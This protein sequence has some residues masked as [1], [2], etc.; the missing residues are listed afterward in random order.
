VCDP[1]N[2]GLGETEDAAQALADA[3]IPVYVI[4][5]VGVNE[6]AMEDIA[7]AGGTDNPLDPDR[8][9]FP[10]DDRDAVVTAL[11]TIAGG[12]IGCSFVAD[13]TTS[14]PPDWGRISV[15]IEV[16]GDVDVVPRDASDGFTVEVTEGA[17]IHLHGAACENL[18][19]AAGA[20]SD[21]EARVRAACATPCTPPSGEACGDAIDNDCDGSRDEDCPAVCGCSE[22]STCFGG[23]PPFDCRP[24]SET[25]DAVDNDCDE[26][27]DEGCCVAA[28]ETCG[29]MIDNDCDGMVDEDCGCGPETCDG[30]DNDCDSMVDEG[31]QPGII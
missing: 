25:C 20:G 31:C 8:S 22:F 4:G 14:Q 6:S 17:V 30:S 10:A 18:Q 13:P 27:V 5:I 23:C 29:D 16:D 1:G 24:V 26:T 12:S 2:G 11:E 3:G 9:W 15:E 21:V 7:V 19:A 28:V